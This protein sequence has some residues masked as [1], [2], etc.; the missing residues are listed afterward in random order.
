MGSNS[1]LIFFFEFSNISPSH[2][3]KL[4]K[5]KKKN[6]IEAKSEPCVNP[7]KILSFYCSKVYNSL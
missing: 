7:S 6:S 3:N 5:K 2:Q 1:D 4:N